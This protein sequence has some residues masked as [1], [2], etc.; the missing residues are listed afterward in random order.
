[1]NRPGNAPAYKLCVDRAVG[2]ARGATLSDRRARRP[3][4]SLQQN[5]EAERSCSL[6]WRTAVLEQSLSSYGKSIFVPQPMLPHRLQ[7]QFRAYMGQK[8][9]RRDF[10]CETQVR[11][12]RNRF[13]RL[14]VLL[15]FQIPRRPPAVNR[16]Q[17]RSN[18]LLDWPRQG[19]FQL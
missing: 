10:E 2:P 1:M 8:P 15:A 18:E 12:P 3:G 6:R 7:C 19:F 13:A 16:A 14:S 5:F 4:T 17:L 11:R 9:F